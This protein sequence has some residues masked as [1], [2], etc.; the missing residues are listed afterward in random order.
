MKARCTILPRSCTVVAVALG[1]WLGLPAGGAAQQVYQ[2]DWRVVGTVTYWTEG[3]D[4][5]ST[6]RRDAS[7]AASLTLVRDP[8]SD[9]RFAF[10]FVGPDGN[11]SGLVPRAIEPALDPNFA[12]PNPLPPGLPRA[13]RRS[14]RGSLAASGAG[15]GGL[16]PAFQIVYSEAFVCHSSAAACGNVR[17]WEVLFIGNARLAP[18][19]PR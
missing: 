1:L 5:D 7:G 17:Q 4:Q 19:A 13:D 10:D 11:G 2:F 3:S 16:P 8:S 18:G 9:V 14:F 6:T 15:G 12:F